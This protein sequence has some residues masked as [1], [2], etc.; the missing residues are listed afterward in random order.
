[1]GKV[2]RLHNKVEPF[3]ALFW[4]LGIVLYLRTPDPARRPGITPP[5]YRQHYHIKAGL[6]QKRRHVAPPPFLSR[7]VIY[8]WCTQYV[9]EKLP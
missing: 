3:G 1:M 8:L 9:K 5:P 2:D 7:F 6:V 4:V